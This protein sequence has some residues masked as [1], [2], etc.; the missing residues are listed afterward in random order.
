[1][2][3]EKKP[4]ALFWGAF[5]VMFAL[6]IIMCTIEVKQISE[7]LM[8]RKDGITVDVVTVDVKE[9]GEGE[10]VYVSYTYNG[11]EYTHTEGS[12]TAV[13]KEIGSSVQGYIHP[14]NPEEL[15]LYHGMSGAAMTFL[16]ISAFLLQLIFG[17]RYIF[18]IVTAVCIAAALIAGAV[19][20]IKSLI[21]SGLILGCIIVSITV[22]A[23]IISKAK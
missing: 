18:A 3:G 15:F 4:Y 5:A 1:M 21:T 19:L 13:S 6:F 9:F 7:L 23:I 14:D 11:K 2:S 12:T 17:K 20:E 16:I 8:L 22:C 10:K